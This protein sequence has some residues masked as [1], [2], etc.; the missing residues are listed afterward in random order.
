MFA[1]TGF[2]PFAKQLTRDAAKQVARNWGPLLLSGVVL[3]VAGI[4]IFSI[5]WTIRELATFIGALFIFQ[6]I[7]EALTTGI[8]ARVRRANVITGLLSV[9]AGVLIIVWPASAGVGRRERDAH[10]ANG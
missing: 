6:G 9:A 3:I 10:Q 1:V 4:V 2:V 5:D 8:D 7:A